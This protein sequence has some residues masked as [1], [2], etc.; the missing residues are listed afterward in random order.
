MNVLQAIWDLWV[1]W[2]TLFVLLGVFVGFADGE[3]STRRRTIL[4]FAAL[5]FYAG[6]GI[7][8][9]GLTVHQLFS[10][11]DFNARGVFFLIA[12]TVAAAIASF[13]IERK[14]SKTR[15]RHRV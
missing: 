10:D 11:D 6:L 5:L 7:W 15:N 4:V 1:L 8:S 12:A 9:M 3:R 14:R 13:F 2:L